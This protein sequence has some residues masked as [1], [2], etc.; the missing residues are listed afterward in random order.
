MRIVSY[1][2]TVCRFSGCKV[3]FIP[4]AFADFGFFLVYL[5]TGGNVKFRDSYLTTHAPYACAHFRK[6][7][8][9][10]DTSLD[11]CLLAASYPSLIM[12]RM[13]SALKLVTP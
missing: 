6:T 11:R 10:S 8:F 12:S 4:A 9:F 5:A 3:A 13:A 1:R 2:A 7:F